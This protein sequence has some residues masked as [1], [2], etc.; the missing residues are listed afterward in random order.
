MPEHRM[1]IIDGSIAVHLELS[2]NGVPRLSNNLA[3]RDA[4]AS[5]DRDPIVIVDTS[6]RY[7]IDDDLQLEALLEDQK[8]R[9]ARA[10]TDAVYFIIELAAPRGALINSNGEIEQRQP[11]SGD[12]RPPRSDDNRRGRELPDDE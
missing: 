2:H 4:A 11:A 12:P 9:Q 8:G 5:R 7:E 1:A 6:P 3:V 10:G